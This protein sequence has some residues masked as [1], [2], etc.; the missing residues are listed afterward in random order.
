M[1]EEGARW[2]RRGSELPCRGGAELGSGT[3][4]LTGQGRVSQAE[5][6]PVWKPHGNVYR[7][8]LAIRQSWYG[9]SRGSDELKCVTLTGVPVHLQGEGMVSLP[10]QEQQPEVGT[11][12]TAS[13]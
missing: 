9:G 5:G 10:A 4:A 12:V 13:S 7:A 3:A 1:K 2:P 8:I 6:K 11:P